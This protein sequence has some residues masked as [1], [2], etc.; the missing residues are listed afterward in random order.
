MD[1]AGSSSVPVPEFTYLIGFF[2][3][4]SSRS[5]LGAISDCR[6]RMEEKVIW[7]RKKERER[8]RVSM[9][10]EFFQSAR[11][12]ARGFT[13]IISTNPQNIPEDGHHS[14]QGKD[15]ATEAHRSEGNCPRVR[16]IWTINIFQA[17]ECLRFPK[18]SKERTKP[19]AAPESRGGYQTTGEHHRKREKDSDGE[20]KNSLKWAVGFRT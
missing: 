20:R 2:T 9:F 6:W 5:F 16:G 13:S 3:Q 17:P 1:Q 10:A 14:S 7:E 4:L 15:G 18:I 12:Y 19:Q 8:E 11:F